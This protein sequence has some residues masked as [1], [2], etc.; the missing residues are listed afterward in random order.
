[1]TWTLFDSSV[2]SFKNFEST[3]E[4]E[5]E[6]VNGNEMSRLSV[7]HEGDRHFYLKQYFQRGRYLRRY[8]GKSRLRAEFENLRYF[9]ELGIP[10]ARIVAYGEDAGIG[11]LV[12]EGLLNVGDLASLAASGDPCLRDCGWR[13]HV[14]HQLSGHVRTIHQNGFVHNDLKWRNILVDPRDGQTKIFMIDCPLGRKMFG[15]FLARG[16]VKDLACLDKVARNVLSRTDRLRFYLRYARKSKLSRADKLRI[17]SI[18]C[19]FDGRE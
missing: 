15:P 10:T 1:V 7:I 18:L 6:L 17:R 4:L 5:G 11:V 13:K 19:F 2:S 12:T 3:R 14:I 8:V 16:V 9:N